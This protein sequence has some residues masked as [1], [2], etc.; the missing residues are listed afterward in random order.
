MALQPRPQLDPF[1][2]AL[3][4]DGNLYIADASKNRIRKVDTTGIIST[5]AGS[6]EGFSGDGGPATAASLSQPTGVAVDHGGNLYIAGFGNIVVRWISK[7]GVI[8]TMAGN[9]QN[10]VFAGDGG[11]A[12]AAQ[13]DPIRVAVSGTTVF[14]VDAIN[15]RVR[16]LTLQTPASLTL[17]GGDNQSGVVGTLLPAALNVT[18]TDQSGIPVAGVTVTFAVTAGS[19]TLNPA[20][21]VTGQDGIASTRVTLGATAGSITITATGSGLTVATFHLTAKAGRRR[22]GGR[23]FERAR[24]QGYLAERNHKCIRTELRA[25]RHAASGRQRRAG[26]WRT[27]DERNEHL[28]PGWHHSGAHLRA[29]RHAGELSGADASHFP[30]R[31]LYKWRPAV[32]RG[33]RW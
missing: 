25:G 10:F 1:D 6:E 5:I 7:S 31:S 14:V 24:S 13:L 4:Q 16:K 23:R 2:I 8:S 21:A 3:D 18:V 26:E 33:T 32:E 17:S 11:Q 9:G 29:D 30:G 22:C 20:S 19:A 12:L 15:D 27:A 28:C